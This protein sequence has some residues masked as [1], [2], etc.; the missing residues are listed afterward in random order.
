LPHSI[1]PGR[2]G[3]FNKRERRCP[4]ALRWKEVSCA[5]IVIGDLSPLPSRV[6]SKMLGPRFFDAAYC[7]EKSYRVAAIRAKVVSSLNGL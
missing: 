4:L 2:D 3:S 5:L 1:G 6:G 7:K